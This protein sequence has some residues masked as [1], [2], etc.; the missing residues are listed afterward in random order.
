MF[1]TTAYILLTLGMGAPSSALMNSLGSIF[2][3]LFC[4]AEDLVYWNKETKM[5]W[6]HHLSPLLKA[7]RWSSAGQEVLIL[8]GMEN[9][10]FS[11]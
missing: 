6:R 11:T 3:F 2:L 8:V 1:A 7:S 9:T 5:A 4:V 10:G